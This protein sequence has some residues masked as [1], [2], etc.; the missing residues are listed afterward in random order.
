MTLTFDLDLE[1]VPSMKFPSLSD[2][3]TSDVILMQRPV[4]EV[5]AEQK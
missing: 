4:T 3:Y 1:V 5:N 2:N